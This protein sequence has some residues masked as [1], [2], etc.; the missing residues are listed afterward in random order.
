MKKDLLNDHNM[1]LSKSSKANYI[2]T[3]AHVSDVVHSTVAHRRTLTVP[4][5]VKDG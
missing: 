2:P 3:H 1:N 5:I 4:F